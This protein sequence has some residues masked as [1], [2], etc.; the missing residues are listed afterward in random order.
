MPTKKVDNIK[1]D[2]V[3]IH[4]LLRTLKEEKGIPAINQGNK[5]LHDVYEIIEKLGEGAF[6]KVYKAKHKGTK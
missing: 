4:E 5:S 6:G 1:Q 3:N 2:N